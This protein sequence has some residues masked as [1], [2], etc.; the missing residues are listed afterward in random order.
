MIA[1]ECIDRAGA[2]RRATIIIGGGTAASSNLVCFSLCLEEL[3]LGGLAG[4][5]VKG[6][7]DRTP[8]PLPVLIR[9]RP[10]C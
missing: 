6:L 1:I 2:G 4:H 10:E 9:R 8:V 5:P 3:E 7:F